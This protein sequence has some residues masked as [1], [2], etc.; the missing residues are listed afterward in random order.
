MKHSHALSNTRE[1]LPLQIRSSI[2]DS[3]IQTRA[4]DSGRSRTLHAGKRFMVL[5]GAQM[6]ETVEPEGRDSAG[7]A[8]PSAEIPRPSWHSVPWAIDSHLP[9]LTLDRI[10]LCSEGLTSLGQSFAFQGLRGIAHSKRE[11]I[12]GAPTFG[13]SAAGEQWGSLKLLL[14]CHARNQRLP[15]SSLG[16]RPSLRMS[17]VWSE[18]VEPASYVLFY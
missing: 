12:N 6:A 9:Y 16:S 15:T 1:A 13:P 5:P 7:Q 8:A 2:D 18:T 4:L 10:S 11:D 14:S 17:F 3:H